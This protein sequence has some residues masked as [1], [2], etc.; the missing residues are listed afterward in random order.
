MSSS[1]SGGGF[2]SFIKSSSGSGAIEDL[3]EEGSELRRLRVPAI[4]DR[5]PPREEKGPSLP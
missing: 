1:S 4:F 2:F 5:Q 3:S